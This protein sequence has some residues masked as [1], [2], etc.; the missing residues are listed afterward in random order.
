MWPKGSDG[1]PNAAGFA[2]IADFL[3]EHLDPR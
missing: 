2:V 3:V 1:H